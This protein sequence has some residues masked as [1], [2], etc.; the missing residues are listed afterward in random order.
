[1]IVLV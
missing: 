1:M